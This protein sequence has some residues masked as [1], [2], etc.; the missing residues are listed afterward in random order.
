MKKYENQLR[1]YTHMSS[2]ITARLFTTRYST[3]SKHGSRKCASKSNIPRNTG[4]SS[5]LILK[6]DGIKIEFITYTYSLMQAKREPNRRLHQ[7][8]IYWK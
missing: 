4:S 8:S 1:S 3:K 5:G 6:H 7:G 2:R